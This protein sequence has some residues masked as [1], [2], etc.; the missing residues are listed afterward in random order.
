MG[1]AR[2]VGQTAIGG[3]ALVLGSA[4]CASPAAHPPSSSPTPVTLPGPVLDAGARPSGEAGQ[5]DGDRVPRAVFPV[6]GQ[7]VNNDRPLVHWRPS[8][9]AAATRVEFCRDRAC[10]SALSTVVS[11]GSRA[12]PDVPLP[13]GCVF[14][15]LTPLDAGVPAS[16]PSQ[17]WEMWVRGKTTSATTAWG[18]RTDVNGDGFAD[19][20]TA[21]RVAY[22]AAGGDLSAHVQD[23]P[24]PAAA[25]VGDVNGDGLGDVVVSSVVAGGSSAS[26]TFT[27]YLGDPRG[28][29]Q[30]SWSVTVPVS[31]PGPLDVRPAGDVNGDGYADFAAV[32]G[33]GGVAIVL[34]G[35]DRLQ[36][37]TSPT[38]FARVPA[39]ML[40]GDVN[41]D[42]V[43]DFVAA[44]IPEDDGVALK[45]TFGS[46]SG[47]S[48]SP[49]ASVPLTSSD[50]TSLSTGY[51]VL[52][53]VSG[54][55]FADLLVRTT[56]TATDTLSLFPGGPAGLATTAS[57]Q[58]PMT[59]FSSVPVHAAAAGNV[60]G[61]AVEDVV[62]GSKD[63]YIVIPAD[64]VT[65]PIVVGTGTTTGVVTKILSVGDVDG[66]G[67][68]DVAW[69]SGGVTRVDFGPIG[70]AGPRAA[71]VV[72]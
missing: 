64:G 40:D 1:V 66:D 7:V 46:A 29:G 47:L 10:S 68:D 34:G 59:A 32:L 43:S 12:A 67:I 27:A 45:V 5:P 52:A 70:P 72:K 2:R 51:G 48:R 30:H 36:L 11:D 53:D 4:V 56:G 60:R 58:I 16:P 9:S 17:P 25:S 15:R 33:N 65:A 50:G 44:G 69:S 35:P 63:R 38:T 55:G 41:G 18:T 6:S 49:N 28:L 54:D 39:D 21:G 57:V 26:V 3:L 61:L 14:W 62:A 42:A 71:R 22:G 20:V 13:R 8:R 23:L 37:G 24:G 19:V 31:S